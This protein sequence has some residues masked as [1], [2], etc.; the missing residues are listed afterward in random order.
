MDQKDR[1]RYFYHVQ[2]GVVKKSDNKRPY[3]GDDEG[4]PR[5]M[6]IGDDDGLAL[7][8]QH[9]KNDSRFDKARL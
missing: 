3:W 1:H 4:V 6:I 2:S 5:N 9:C 7:Y 8:P